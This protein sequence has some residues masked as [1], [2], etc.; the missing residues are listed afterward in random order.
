VARG[1]LSLPA[2]SECDMQTASQWTRGAGRRGLIAQAERSSASDK[3]WVC[4][5][6]YQA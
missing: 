3:R 2:Y 6:S 4:D 1:S 5:Q